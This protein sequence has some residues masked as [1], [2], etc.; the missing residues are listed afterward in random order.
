MEGFYSCLFS[1]PAPRLIL[2]VQ[3]TS[4]FI[5]PGLIFLFLIFGPVKPLQD[6]VDRFW[7][8]DYRPWFRP[9]QLFSE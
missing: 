9:Y 8:T 7:I 2:P 6:L 1:R 3:T 5:L 4:F